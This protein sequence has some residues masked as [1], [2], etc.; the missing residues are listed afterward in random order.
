MYHIHQNRSNCRNLTL[1]STLVRSLKNIL[2]FAAS[3]RKPIFVGTAVSYANSTAPSG[4]L[5][6][7]KRRTQQVFLVWELYCTYK[8]FE[9]VSI[10]L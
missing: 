3:S 4:H 6:F 9:L 10:H 8:N 7:K 1:K 2:F 5:L